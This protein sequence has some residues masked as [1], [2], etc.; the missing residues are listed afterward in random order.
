MKICENILTVRLH[1]AADEGR[2]QDRTIWSLD[3]GGC[4]AHSLM[5][6]HRRCPEQPG[7]GV[8]VVEM[9]ILTYI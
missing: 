2:R 8:V 6:L 4:E 1:H 9:I 3:V 5:S 7:S